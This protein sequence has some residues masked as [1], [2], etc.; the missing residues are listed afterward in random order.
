MKPSDWDFSLFLEIAPEE[1]FSSPGT[2]Q[3]LPRETRSSFSL[4][5]KDVIQL[6]LSGKPGALEAL[7]LLPR[8][9]APSNLRGRTATSKILEFITLFRAGQFKALWERPNII[10]RYGSFDPAK[11]AIAL[12]K[13]GNLG[14][15]VRALASEGVLD[16]KDHIDK[17]KQL[18][19]DAPLPAVPDPVP[20]S[21][22]TQ[23][24]NKADFHL[25]V[26]H[27]KWKKA[28]DALGWRMDHVKILS[29]EALN[30]LFPLCLRM[31][32]NPRLIP[33]RLR[34]FFFGAR[35]TPIG[36]K[37]GGIRPI[38]IGTIFS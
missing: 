8:L 35:L 14:D 28:A 2:I 20:K 32:K 12:A 13:A 1:M 4:L 18:H 10:L 11:R 19:P 22:L 29:Q 17:L 25:V 15:A 6:A 36:K 34:P 27:A 37:D 23:P 24:F 21:R 30:V 38:A 9:V 31:A 16:P 5:V 33:E 3:S 7:L 26:K